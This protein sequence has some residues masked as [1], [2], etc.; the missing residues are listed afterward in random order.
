MGSTN[1]CQRRRQRRVTDG[2]Y[3]FALNI[4]LGIIF[5]FFLFSGG[6]TQCAKS[7][8]IFISRADLSRE[9]KEMDQ[10]R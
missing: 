5:L 7:L 4:F 2:I 8:A 6:E 3:F 10:L 1:F 9:I